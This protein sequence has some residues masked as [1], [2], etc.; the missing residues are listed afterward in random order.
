MLN[1]SQIGK[2]VKIA[3]INV[4]ITQ[5]CLAEQLGVS[6]V[7][8]SNI[9]R[10]ATK[11]GLSVLVDISKI[12]RVSLDVLVCNEIGTPYQRAI[13]D[14]NVSDLLNDCTPKELLVIRDVIEC[15]KKSLHRV[16]SE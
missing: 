3:R 2:Q 15:T 4:G 5:E 1:Y 7:H 13:L 12:L 16:Y 14:N 6:S 11:V 9:E 10:G 8:V